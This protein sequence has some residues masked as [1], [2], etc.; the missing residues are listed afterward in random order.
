[1]AVKGQD[2]AS[3]QSAAPSTTGLSFVFVKAT[4]STNYTNPRHADQVAHARA[5]GL[6]VGH[7]LFQRPTNVTLQANYF[8]AH[9]GVK[10]GD[11]IALDWEDTAVSCA[12]K[13]AMIKTLQKL[14]P[15][16][17]VVLYCNKDF[18]LHRDTTSVCGDGLW[19]ADPSAPAGK[20]SVEHA[21]TFHQYSISGGTDQ[22]VAN[23]ATAANLKAWA[24]GTVASTPKTTNTTVKEKTV[25]TQIVDI[26][27]AGDIG[28]VDPNTPSGRKEYGVGYY[29]AHLLDEQRKTNALLTLIAGQQKPTAS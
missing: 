6:V 14:F 16:S 2:W 18:W 21:W 26:P 27:P 9:A 13:D 10:P 8:A 7:Y 28:T 4:E 19:I 20:P 1:M 15:K 25:A 24:T 5:A 17:R 22:N 29:L 23:F 3:Y 12:N 11:M